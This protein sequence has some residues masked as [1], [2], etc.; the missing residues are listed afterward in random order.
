MNLPAARELPSVSTDEDGNPGKDA[1]M[2][3]R[4]KWFNERY[5]T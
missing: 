5:K 2:E 3:V 1:P 4:Q